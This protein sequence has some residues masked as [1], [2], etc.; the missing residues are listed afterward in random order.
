MAHRGHPGHSLR[1]PATHLAG[2]HTQKPPAASGATPA[3]PFDLPVP[4]PTDE[5]ESDIEARNLVDESGAPK[6]TD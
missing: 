1:T 4:D 2:P 3:N 6:I 5:I